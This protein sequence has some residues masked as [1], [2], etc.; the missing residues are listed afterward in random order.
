MKLEKKYW[1]PAG[2]LAVFEIQP[3]KNETTHLPM[4]FS[5][6]L[7]LNSE[8]FDR[9]VKSKPLETSKVQLG[10]CKKLLTRIN[11]SF[12]DP[13]AA[14][15]RHLTWVRRWAIKSWMPRIFR[16]TGREGVNGS[17]LEVISY[18]F[19]VGG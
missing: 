4:K 15:C 5:V 10:F 16:P 6:K 19:L 2:V 12:C 7:P 13:T 8:S 9:L 3:K 11:N 1:I 17:M 14:G 18:T